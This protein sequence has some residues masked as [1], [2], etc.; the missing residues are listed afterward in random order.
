VGNLKTY[1][2]GLLWRYKEDE[3]REENEIKITTFVPTQGGR[4]KG[5]KNLTPKITL[6]KIIETIEKFKGS[7]TFPTQTLVA[8]RLKVNNKT[9]QRCLKNAGIDLK[10]NDYVHSIISS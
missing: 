7:Y 2:K 4:I 9:I 6:N 5:T 8:R 10:Y 3:V 1:F